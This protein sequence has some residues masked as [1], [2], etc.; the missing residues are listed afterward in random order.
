MAE[1]R[2]A[3]E[4]DLPTLLDVFFRAVDDLIARQGRPTSR[5]HPG[6][7]EQ[8]IRHL[9]VTDPGTALLAEER[10]E[11]VAFGILHV[12]DA[13]AFLSFLF[14]LPGHQARGLGRTLAERCLETGLGGRA[15]VCADADQPVAIG[16]Y[17]SLGMVPRVPLYVLRG[18]P[19][20]EALPSL[21][22]GSRMTP[23]KLA[24]GDDL[25][26]RLLGYRRPMDHAFWRASLR[27]GWQLEDHAGRIIGYGYAQASGRVGPV[28]AEA[29]E[30]VAPILGHLARSLRPTDGWQVV[31]PGPAAEALRTLLGGGLRI[32][33]GPAV[34]C[35]DHAGPAFDRYLPM[36]FALL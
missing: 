35:A 5:P 1:V 36:S 29:P 14:V 17:S 27:E 26:E 9:L 33:G 4:A 21:P 6:A 2:R 15:G 20:S 23:L 16:L 8:I 28:A 30:H 11:V 13:D 34:Y 32:D 22:G 3:V 7:L 10:G 19:R 31:V 25:D 24:A 18:V 12:R